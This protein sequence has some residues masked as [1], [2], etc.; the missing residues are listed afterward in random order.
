MFFV[1][2]LSLMSTSLYPNSSQSLAR[3]FRVYHIQVIAMKLM[4][5][6]VPIVL[7]L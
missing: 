7:Q 3:D 4:P 1:R 5:A 2:I 6:I